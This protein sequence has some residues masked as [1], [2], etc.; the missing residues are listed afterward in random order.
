MAKT[1][2][3]I[4]L[5]GDGMD[6]DY[7]EFD[8][9]DDD[10]DEMA[11]IDAISDLGEPFLRDFTR[12]A[13][14]AFF[15]QYGLISHQ[16]NS[17]NDFIRN[18]I[19]RVIDDFG[20]LE[21]EP[22]YDPSRKGDAEWKHAVVR[23]GKVTI[24]KPQFWAGDK[25]A[26]SGKGY[27]DVLPRHARLQNM[28]YAS[29]M[30]VTVSIRV[31]IPK[32]VSSDKFKTGKEQSL[33]HEPVFE[34]TKE[35][36]AG[37][38]PIMV[39][40]DLCWMSVKS[41][42]E[43]V[44]L[45]DYGHDDSRVSNVL[46]ASIYEADEKCEGF[47]RAGKALSYVDKNIKSC[48]FPPT[49]SISEC[50]N[51]YLFPTLSGAGNKVKA[52]FLAYMVRCLL[53]AYTGRRKCDSKDDFKNKRLDMAGE[54][55]ER[56]IRVQI[57]NARRRM[58]RAIQRDL[59]A[60]RNL[61]DIENYLDA[62]I[63]TNGL[64][65]AF[66][67]GAWSHPF[68]AERI[69]GVVATLRRQNPLQTVSDMRKLRQ[70]VNYTGKVGDARYPHPSHWGKVCFL[71]TPD[72][73]NCGLVKNLA[74]TGLV[75]INISESLYEKLLDW[76]MQG[77]VDDTST[78]LCGKV[79]VFLNGD[80]IGV[81]EDSLAFVTQLRNKRRH[82]EIPPEVEIKRDEHHGEVRMYSDAGRVL[83]PLLVV[84]NLKKIPTLKGSSFTFQNLLDKG[85]I[86]L[87]GAEEEEDCCTAWGIRYILRERESKNPVKYTHYYKRHCNSG[88]TLPVI[89]P[90]DAGA[91]WT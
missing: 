59:Y 28:T 78:S 15:D 33:Q 54:L 20:D 73:E 87:I 36:L 62:S 22:G 43:V 81:C 44:D 46:L 29:R 47:R 2:D 17:F 30:K 55:L 1:S 88:W 77:V 48:K 45:I 50:F 69:S 10:D 58:L 39:K 25:L 82:K 61:R 56:E 37:R 51:N 90:E 12:K 21:I 8:D 79:K 57:L 4:P 24:D 3:V 40:S 26:E 89:L 84:E 27:L 72:G 35:V 74:A 83:R 31:Y 85:I 91:Q 9:E 80:W 38:I 67:T 32:L 53:E 23:F 64:Q 34:E 13:A 18:G 19:Q 11:A 75:T 14:T 52:R 66:S 76:G 7:D 71:S 60:D 42:K 6:I 86:E 65:R 5:N 63:I 41:D 49:E 70:Q 68:K 16:I